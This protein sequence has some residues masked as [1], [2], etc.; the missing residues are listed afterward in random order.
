MSTENSGGWR[1]EA[2]ELEELKYYQMNTN[3]II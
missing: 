3:Y 1:R 2:H